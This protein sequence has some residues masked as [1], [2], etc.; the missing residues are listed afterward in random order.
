M[1]DQWLAERFEAHRTH[2]RGVCYRMLGSLSE[3]DDAVQEALLAD[4]VGI[5]RLVVLDTLA[6]AERLNGAVGIAVAPH[7][8]LTTVIP[9]RSTGRRSSKSTCTRTL[10]DCAGSTWQS[11][12]DLT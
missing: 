1:D 6:P 11:S 2:L 7:G 5:A 9:S 3:A 12:T 10:S 8:R 4:S